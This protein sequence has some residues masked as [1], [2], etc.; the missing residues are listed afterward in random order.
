MK[1]LLE[2]ATGNSMT[3]KEIRDLTISTLIDLSKSQAKSAG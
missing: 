2:R 3:V 1:Q